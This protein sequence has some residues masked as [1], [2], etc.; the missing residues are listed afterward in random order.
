MLPGTW[1]S[2]AVVTCTCGALMRV[3]D[4]WLLDSL[5]CGNCGR[6]VHVTDQN[7]SKDTGKTPS[8]LVRMAERE[9]VAQRHAMAIELVRERK[10]DE[11]IELYESVLAEKRDHRDSLYG[12]GYCH[13]K[14]CNYTEAYRLI[15]MAAA[16]GHTAANRILDKVR[17]KMQDA[18]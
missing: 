9:G 3:A 16:M 7:T 14:K 5:T 8:A 18:S 17:E 15:S 13:Y 4:P 12:I 11:A 1:T 10:Y 2:D 6:K